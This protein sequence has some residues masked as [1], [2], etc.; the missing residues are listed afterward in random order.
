MQQGYNSK[1]VLDNERN[2]ILFVGSFHKREIFFSLLRPIEYDAFVRVF[3][4]FQ[5]FSPFFF[6]VYVL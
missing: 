3:E 2:T 5:L 6:H 4:N 1:Y